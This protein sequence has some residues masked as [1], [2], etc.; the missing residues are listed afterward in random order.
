MHVKTKRFCTDA[1]A[2]ARSISLT[3]T[4]KAKPGNG[5]AI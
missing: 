3:L 4:Q 5:G 1:G 2:S